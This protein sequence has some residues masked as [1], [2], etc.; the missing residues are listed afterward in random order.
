MIAM[1]KTTQ[2]SQFK[3]EMHMNKLQ[4]SVYF[5]SAKFDEYEKDKKQKEEKKIF[6]RQ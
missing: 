6:R 5:I 4:E 2:E 3:G 1:V